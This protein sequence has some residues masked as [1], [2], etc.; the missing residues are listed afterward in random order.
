MYA[1]DALQYDKE[2]FKIGIPVLGICYG[3]QMLNKEFGGSVERKDGR[4]DGQF[5]ITVET[6]SPLFW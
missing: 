6:S 2:I 5:T 1:E 4:E 3:F